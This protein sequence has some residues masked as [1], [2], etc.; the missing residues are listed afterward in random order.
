MND[1]KKIKVIF[2]TNIWISFLI[3]KRLH[4]LKPLISD[5]TLEI[6][7]SD[8]IIH[9]IQ[10]VTRRSKLKPYFTKQKVNELIGLLVMIGSHYDAVPKNDILKDEK[11]NFLLDLI[12]ASSADILVTGDKELLDLGNFMGAKILSARAFEDELG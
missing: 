5:R 4:F 10:E 3:G 11:D 1:P 12:E 9:E 6:V 8:Q 7:I 2:D